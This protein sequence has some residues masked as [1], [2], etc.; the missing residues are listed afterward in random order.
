MVMVMVMGWVRCL[1]PAKGKVEAAVGLGRPFPESP[2]AVYCT[3]QDLFQFPAGQGRSD[4]EI[5]WPVSTH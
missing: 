1:L 5:F 4:Q 2:L 3:C